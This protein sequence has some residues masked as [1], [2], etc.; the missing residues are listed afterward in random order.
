M[1]EH[2]IGNDAMEVH[3]EVERAAEACTKVIAPARDT[4]APALVGEDRGAMSR[5][6]VMS[7]GSRASRNRAQRGSD[8]TLA[9]KPATRV[10]RGETP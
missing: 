4:S 5:L 10:S 7:I 9:R 3:I 8:K 1:D 6:R 2:A